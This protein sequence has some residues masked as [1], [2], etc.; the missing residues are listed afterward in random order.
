M[1]IAPFFADS[2]DK[3]ASMHDA[4][5]A[6]PHARPSHGFIFGARYIRIIRCFRFIFFGF[7]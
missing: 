3:R 6:S 2:R 4:N 1:G 5:T 7:R